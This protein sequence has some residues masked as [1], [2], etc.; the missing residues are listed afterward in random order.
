MNTISP[1][2]VHSSDVLPQQAKMLLR[3]ATPLKRL[4]TEEEI[5][6]T[7]MFLLE[8]G[9]LISGADIPMTGGRVSLG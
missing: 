1:G 7:V 9:E 2:A 4:V 8:S 6:A 5:T 3:N